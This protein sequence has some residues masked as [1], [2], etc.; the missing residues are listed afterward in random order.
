MNS[1]PS[2][3]R[4][5]SFPAV[6]AASCLLVSVSLAEDPPQQNRKLKVASVDRSK[7]RSFSAPDGAWTLRNDNGQEIQAHLLSAHGE[8]IK[9]QRVEDEREFDV[10]ISAFDDPTQDRIRNWMEEDPD[11]ISYNIAI[12]TQRNLVDSSEL[13]TGGKTFKNSKWAYRVTVSNLTRND[14]NNAKVEY[15]I[16]YDDKVTFSRNVPMPGDGQNRQDGQAV[17][18]PEM[19]FNDEIEFVT[20][21]VETQTYKYEP[22]KGEREYAKDEVKGIWVR[23]VRHD[24]VI[25]E[26]RSNEAFMKSLSWD[27]EDQVEIK[28]TNK[29]RDSFSEE[30]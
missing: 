22:T 23:V 17:D 2:F 12:K 11:A 13:K 25:A 20:P 14:L 24:E 26:Y 8:T 4:G 29:F 6:A 7:M 10:P 27:N 28:V 19:A 5:L 18:L 30:E 3:L 16:V 15:R 1:E 9:I 21:P